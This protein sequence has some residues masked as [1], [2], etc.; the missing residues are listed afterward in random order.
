VKLFTKVMTNRLRPAIAAI[1][2]ADQTGFIHS[3]SIAENFVYAADLLSSCHKRG[4]PTA[5]LKLDFKKAFDSI[6]W[7]SLDAF[8]WSAALITGGEAGFQRFCPL[9]RQRLCSTVSLAAGLLA[10]GG[11]GKAILSLHIS[12]SLS[13]MSYGACSSRHRTVAN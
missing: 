9:G 5:A 1:V 13:P 4:L 11:S 7:S 6:E 8:S 3:R 10:V 2:D 12:S